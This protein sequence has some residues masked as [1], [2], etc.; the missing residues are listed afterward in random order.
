MVSCI[1]D[2]AGT[3][4]FDFSNDASRVLTFPPFGFVVSAGVHKFQNAI[5][6][7]RYFRVR[8]V[9]ED[10]LDRM[11]IYIKFQNMEDIK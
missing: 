10:W 9:R 1:T 7:G 6:G 8:F 3:L 5:K 4:Y 2:Q 11:G